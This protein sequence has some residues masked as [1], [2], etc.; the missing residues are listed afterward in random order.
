L[1]LYYFLYDLGSHG[2]TLKIEKYK[3]DSTLVSYT[4]YKYKKGKY[5]IP[6]EEQTFDNGE[7]TFSITRK[8]N[9]YGDE[10]ESQV[11][12]YADSRIETYKSTY[13][14]DGLVQG[15]TLEIEFTDSINDLEFIEPPMKSVYFYVYE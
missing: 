4:A 9:V 11:H 14:S 6:I 15:F 10:I 13:D 7:L 5:R 3:S 8:L 2:E 12:W 1:G